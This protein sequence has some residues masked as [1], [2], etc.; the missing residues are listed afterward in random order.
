MRELWLSKSKRVYIKDTTTSFTNFYKLVA[1][2]YKNIKISCLN[3][4]SIRSKLDD[5]AALVTNAVDIYLYPEQ[6]WM[7]HF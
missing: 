5:L 1:D 6:N 3:V 7:I 4:N 2:Q